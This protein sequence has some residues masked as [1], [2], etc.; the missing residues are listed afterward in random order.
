MGLALL[1]DLALV[2]ED[3]PHLKGGEGPVVDRDLVHTTCERPAIGSG[4][5]TTADLQGL[6][7]QTHT[8]ADV[9]AF[10]KAA[11]DV[12]SQL[13]A[14]ISHHD[15]V[16]LVQDQRSR[17]SERLLIGTIDP[18]ASRDLRAIAGDEQTLR[19]PNTL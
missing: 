8:A 15:V 13:A 1:H 9:Q 14:I 19:F 11:V 7:V 2:E 18:D 17:A 10:V 6:I 12:K 3:V 4:F 5:Q 16:P